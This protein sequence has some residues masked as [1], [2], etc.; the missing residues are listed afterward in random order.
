MGKEL[1]RQK[2]LG[3]FDMYEPANESVTSKFCFVVG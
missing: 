1:K 2:Y 3:L